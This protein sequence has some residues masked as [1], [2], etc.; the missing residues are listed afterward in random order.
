MCGLLEIEATNQ[1]CRKIDSSASRSRRR[2]MSAPGHPAEPAPAHGAQETGV[3]TSRTM[4]DPRRPRR[5]L[6]AGTEHEH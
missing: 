1:T 5:G 6:T 2:E 3:N 4:S